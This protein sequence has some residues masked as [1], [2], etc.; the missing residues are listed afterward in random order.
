VTYTDSTALVQ[1][2]LAM[3][4]TFDWQGG[5]IGGGGNLQTSGATS[6]ASATAKRLTGLTWEN[7][8]SLAWTGG[9]IEIDS[10]SVLRNRSGGTFRVAVVDDV[11]RIAGDGAF[12][13]GS[14]GSFIVEAGQSCVVGT[15]FGNTGLVQ[16]DGRLTLLSDFRNQGVLRLGTNGALT[17]DAELGSYDAF[18]NG[19][20]GRIEGNGR[21]DVRGA[22]FAF[23]NDGVMAPG[24]SPGVLTI[25]GDFVQDDTGILDI[26]LGGSVAGTDYDQLVVTGNASLGGTLRLSTIDGA[27]LQPG[28][29][30]DV[31]RYASTSGAFASTVQP[32]QANVLAT[33]GLTAYSLQLAGVVDPVLAP[34]RSVLVFDAP[35]ALAQ[36]LTL[37][38]PG[39]DNPVQ[40]IP[41]LRGGACN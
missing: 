3:A 35:Q 12:E 31:L 28:S 22:G 24:S 38:D 32:A 11:A 27:G 16:L 8:G 5:S 25:Q 39:T 36:T 2:T 14:G 21:I 4:G 1:G 15:G 29:S 37:L 23:I 40:F 20:D 7:T 13:N 17:T 41:R 26:Q 30:F 10:E 9:R 33:T 19:T 34:E 18:G 6:L